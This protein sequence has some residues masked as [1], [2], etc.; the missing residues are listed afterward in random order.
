MTDRPAGR[1][2][3]IQ[4]AVAHFGKSE[5]TLYRWADAGKIETK[6]EDNR[7]FVFVPDP[8]PDPDQVKPAEVVKL[9]SQV[10]ALQ[11]KVDMLVSQLTEAKADRDRW[12]DQAEDWKRQS[13]A[14]TQ[15]VND[16]QKLLT[17]T[18]A[19]AEKEENRTE[20][21][22]PDQDRPQRSPWWK[23]LFE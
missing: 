18:T 14:L 21:T 2:L 4:E 1:W 7:T 20:P 19:P 9:Q 3:P 22:A 23:R 15:V 12:I 17:A 11:T 5:R 16:Q 13:A 10:D 6:L 8:E